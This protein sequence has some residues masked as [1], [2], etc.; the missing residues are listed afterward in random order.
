MRMCKDACAIDKLH[1]GLSFM[2]AA[3]CSL[4][5]AVCC[6]VP[7]VC[8]LLAAVLHAHVQRRLRHR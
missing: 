2:L 1:E 7:A 6:F 5:S 8:C 4:L 3:R